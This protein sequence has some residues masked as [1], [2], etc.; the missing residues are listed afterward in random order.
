V[1]FGKA[2]EE[3]AARSRMDSNIGVAMASPDART[4]DF[5]R[6]VDEKEVS[7]ILSMMLSLRLRTATKAEHIELVARHRPGETLGQFD[8]VEDIYND[9][10][11]LGRKGKLTWPGKKLKS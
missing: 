6:E 7:L 11:K 4:I 10:M 9:Y 5:N 3:A 1:N 2:L 8:A